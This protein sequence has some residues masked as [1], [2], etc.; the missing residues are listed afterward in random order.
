VDT[1]NQIYTIGYGGRSI[2]EFV[3][4]VSDVAAE[5]VVDVR[6]SP[7]SKYKPEFSREPLSA[8]LERSGVRYVFMGDALGGRPDD[9]S[10]YDADGRVDYGR[11]RLRPEFQEGLA[12]LEAG[13]EGGSR[14]VL[15]CSEGRPQDCHRTKLVAAE[16]VALGIPVAHID[17]LDQLRTPEEVND[18]V[19]DGQGTLF[20]EHAQAAR[21]RKAYR[22]A[23]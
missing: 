2:D 9:P 16:L 17:E 18:L 12:V 6:S 15:M 3:S 7:Y 8:R 20:G 13:V 5:Y 21:S 22:A 10:C 23:S 14:L 11:C 1:A 4:A 19:T